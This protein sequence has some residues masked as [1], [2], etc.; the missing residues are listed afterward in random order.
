M[1]SSNNNE[2]P[3]N[4]EFDAIQRQINQKTDDSLQSTRRMLGL[5]AESQEVGV[6]T[7]IQLD[8]QGEKLNKIEVNIFSMIF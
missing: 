1:Q 3:V 5:V 8:E 7:M 4:D 6:N 2:G